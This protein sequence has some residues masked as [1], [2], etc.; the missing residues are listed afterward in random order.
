[1]IHAS[2]D[3]I[4]T[5]TAAVFG[6]G[7]FWT[8]LATKQSKKR[9][10][11]EPEQIDRMTSYLIASGQDRII[12]L[13]ERY[14]DAG[15]ISLRDW[16]MYKQMYIAYHNMGGDSLAT[17]VYE[18]VERLHTKGEKRNGRKEEQ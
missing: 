16:S 7:G 17:D 13:G 18:E 4:A 9:R 3:M 11:V 15:H 5:L 10:R 1:M 2:W 14:L 12:W 8:W 6:S